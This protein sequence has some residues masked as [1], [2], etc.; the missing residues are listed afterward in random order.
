MCLELNKNSVK[1]TALEDITVYKHLEKSEM[2]HLT[3]TY[4]CCPVEIGETYTSELEANT[5]GPPNHEFKSLE[6]GL[7]SFE[8]LISTKQDAAD[9]CEGD[10]V[11]VKCVIPKNAN[12]YV[13]TFWCY[14]CFASDKLTYV[15]IIS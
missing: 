9:T 14:K 5:I 2:G 12:Y 11:I 3:T 15:E 1:C 10:Y 8:S 6:K 4:M 7:H 13:G